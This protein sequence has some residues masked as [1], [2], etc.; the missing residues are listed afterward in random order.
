MLDT[1]TN[2]TIEFKLP[3]NTIPSEWLRIAERIWNDG[4]TL[5]NWRQHY[6]RLQECLEVPDPDNL[7]DLS[8]PVAIEKIKVGSNYYLHCWI[9]R[10]T[11]I[12]KSK[13]WDE[14]NLTFVPSVRLV[15]S[16]WNEVPPIDRRTAF[17]LCK[18]FTKKAGYDYGSLPS[19]LMQSVVTNLCDAWAKYLKTGAGKPKYKGIKNPV[20]SLSYDGFR[21]FCE[22]RGAAVK[23]VGMPPVEVFG[24][25]RLT[26]KIE[27]T[28]L[29]LLAAPTDR[30]VKMGEKL[31]TGGAAAF[32]SLP[33]V[34]HLIKR[35]TGDYIQFAGEFAVNLAALKTD[36][37]I[38][39]VGG[40]LLYK[41]GDVEIEPLN[42]SKIARRIINLQRVLAT[43]KTHSRNW[44]KLQDK[45]RSLQ[46]QQARSIRSHQH[47]HAQWLADRYGEISIV[48]LPPI[49]VPVPVPIAD[50]TGG[51][52]P[53]G[54]TAVSECNL[55]SAR[56]AIG[57][58]VEL[59]KQ[60]CILK[61]REFHG[62]VENEPAAPSPVI[63]SPNRAIEPGQPQSNEGQTGGNR[64]R[65]PTSTKTRNRRRETAI[66]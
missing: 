46:R 33:G 39:V 44:H 41:V 22:I 54:A 5:L 16:H 8:R 29:F 43:K 13:S 4:L 61:R 19:G 49:V 64:K 51:Y 3:D 56:L 63:N 37:A 7:F 53:N 23:L 40:S 20:T 2:Q 25:H 17:T 1:L 12:D 9:G 35:P 31:G 45:I 6:L 34:Y 38:V 52:A 59:I 42:T 30:V 14:A 26:A 50:G 28:R 24:L 15:R 11:R 66:G 48:K 36:L 60:E 65:L 47:Y 57:Q 55:K 58:F 27:R 32:Y 18:Q 21:S 10:D 62:I